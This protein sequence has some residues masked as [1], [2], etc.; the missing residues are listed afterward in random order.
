MILGYSVNDTVVIYDYIRENRRKYKA[1]AWP[2]LIQM[3][4]CL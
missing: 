3:L 2:D 4:W 1:M